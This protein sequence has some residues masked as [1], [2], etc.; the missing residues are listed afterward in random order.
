MGKAHKKDTFK[1][2]LFIPKILR[3]VPQHQKTIAQTYL[4]H[5]RG[6]FWSTRTRILSWYAIIL[7][8]IFL[9]FIPAFRQA[10]YARVNNRVHDDIKEKIQ[11][12]DQL[13]GDITNNSEPLDEE[14]IESI[15]KLRST[16]NRLLQAPTSKQEL[17]EFFDAFLGNQLPNDDTF[18]IALMDDKFY[19]SSPR[20][21]P[22]AMDRDAKIIRNWAKLT[23][24]EQ[25]EKVLHNDEVDSIIYL[26]RPVKI[27]NE[28]MGVLVIAHT[29]AG[30]R[31]EVLEAV[32]VIVQVSIIVVIFALV[33]A[34]FAAGKILA[35]LRLLTQTT[36]KISETDL[37]QRITIDGSGE[38]A[39]LGATFNA[40]MD[41]LQ[42]AFIS[43]RNFI[44]DAGH[45]L[46]T[47]ITII[48][49]HLELMGD[50]PQERQET[51]TIVMDELERMNRFVNDLMLLAKAEQPDFLQLE[52]ID[53]QTFTK[54]LFAKVRGLGDR[55]WQLEAVARGKIVGDR[56]RLT[57][58]I[59]N[60][61]QNATQHTNN[62]D[63]ISLGSRIYGGQVNFWVRDTGTGIPKADQQRIFQ[64]FARAANSRR[65]SDGAGLGLSI[66]Q[67]IAE[68]HRGK[69][70]LESEVGE[71]SIFR[72]I[73]PLETL[74]ETTLII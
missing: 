1:I 9:V 71:G 73:L 27:N 4:K 22:K 31:A 19:K 37:N 48:R 20:A 2:F 44:N 51:L 23:Q 66:V 61:A 57:Q 56:Q 40:M 29:T 30:E 12:F 5:R 33:L 72:I 63:T 35:P 25:G 39:E 68:A 24:S 3:L 14:I 17:R 32:A 50:D 70:T 67:V 38:L 60:L 11:V 46:R 10:L 55:I 69:I 65:R 53:V 21:R 54:E 7:F 28:V 16:D 43:Q 18:L 41:R 74:P 13:I 6:F 15:D 26:A 45:E 59:M 49:G 36:R 52:T 64:R 8:L 34:W 47:P 42:D 62:T 58:A